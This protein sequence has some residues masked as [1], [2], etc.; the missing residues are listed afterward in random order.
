MVGGGTFDNL[1]VSEKCMQPSWT[2]RQILAIL[3]GLTIMV[4]LF[5]ALVLVGL[6]PAFVREGLAGPRDLIVRVATAGVSPEHWNTA[7]TRM[8]V[9]LIT[10]LAAGIILFV[11]QRY[12]GRKLSSR[13]PRC[14]PHLSNPDCS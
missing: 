3:R 12:L 8:Q 9:A 5:W 1:P 14:Q 4:G 10:T 13:R 7:I 6:L 2:L 11:A